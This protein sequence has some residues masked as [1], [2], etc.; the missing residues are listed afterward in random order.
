[1]GSSKCLAYLIRVH[2][3]FPDHFDG[4]LLVGL[5]VSSSID[6][7]E[8]SIAHLLNEDESVQA[9]IFGHLTSLLSFFGD[10]GMNLGISTLHLLVFGGGMGSSTSSLGSDISIVAGLDRV[11]IMRLWLMFH[12]AKV[13]FAYSMSRIFLLLS[14]NRGDI[15]GGLIARWVGTSGL[16]AMTYEVLEVLYGRHFSVWE[17]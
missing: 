1:M 13:G 15:R 7:A 14:M 16:L 2:F 10:D 9:G 6:V 5:G 17:S 12:L 8:R 4:D 3:E 11:V